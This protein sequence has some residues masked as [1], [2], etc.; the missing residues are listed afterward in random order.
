M[1]DNHAR[2]PI[3]QQVSLPAH[4]DAPVVLEAAGPL[5]IGYECRAHLP[6]GTLD[7][8]VISEQANRH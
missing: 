4:F 5:G 2:R 6:D 7:E 8:V 3:G 1:T